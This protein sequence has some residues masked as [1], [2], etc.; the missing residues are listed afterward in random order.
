MI[1][2]LW[3]GKTHFYWLLMPLSWLYGLITLVR[4]QLYK[5]GILKSWKSPVP[6]IVIGNLSVG[7]NGKT[8]LVIGLIEALKTKG[9]KI[10][11]VSRGYGGKAD[12]YPLILD[13]Q[14]T[15]AQAGDEPVL[16]YQR[17]HVPV[18]VSPN[19]SQ[20]VQALLDNYQLDAILT[21]DGL[22]HYA[23]KRD[24]EIVVVDGKRL[25]GNGWWIPAGPMRERQSRLKSVDIIII[26][27][28][29]KSHLAEKFPEKTYTMQLKPQ[30]A[31]NL[32]TKEKIE[33]HSLKNICAMAGIGDPN[34]F[35]TML[36]TL[37]ADVIKT[38]SFADHQNYTLPLLANIATQDQTLLMT[39]KDAVKCFQFTLPNWWYLPI[40]AIL[41]NQVTNQIC[42]LLE[43]IKSKRE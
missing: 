34:R 7:G 33:L 17:T 21:D 8:P 39:E 4:R 37:K 41:P 6:I 32:L 29:T 5:A 16:I 30:Y 1:E 2:K 12:S 23:L 11:V 10:G 9:L 25:F 18:A 38:V 42:S 14:T 20:A 19:R 27:G 36:N 28:E 3:Y 35:F 40:E 31:V 24:I 13:E 22:Q 26:N 43:E 15:T